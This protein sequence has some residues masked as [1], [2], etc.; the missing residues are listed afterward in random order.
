MAGEQAVQ[1]LRKSFNQQHSWE[2]KYKLMISMGK[3]LPEMS[4]ELKVEENKVR[5]CQSQVWLFAELKN[6]QVFFQ[7]DSDAS[8]V[9]GIVAILLK[10]YSGLKP[11]EILAL[12]PQFIEDLG[13]KQHLSLSRANGL[14]AMLKQISLY[15]L[16]FDAKLKMG[17]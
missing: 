16:A 7:G 6:G 12:E 8:I 2:D 13:L 11:Q 14:S 17:V 3:D 4:D 1:E 5:G 15:A 9:K 10:I